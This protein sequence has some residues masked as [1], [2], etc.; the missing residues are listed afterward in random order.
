MKKKHIKSKNIINLWTK[1]VDKWY[2]WKV[3]SI[4][5]QYM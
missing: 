2:F 1:Q 5:E 3:Y 4:P